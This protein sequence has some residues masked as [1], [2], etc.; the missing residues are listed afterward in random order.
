VGSTHRDSPH[1][2]GVSYFS[3]KG[4][5]GDGRAKPDLVAPGEKIVS[6]ATSWSAASPPGQMAVLKQQ[7]AQWGTPA[8]PAA[9]A[10]AAPAAMPPRV[11]AQY[12]EDSGTSMAAPHVSGAIAAFL[13]VRREYIGEPEKVKEVFVSTATDLKRDRYFQGTGLVDLMRAIQSV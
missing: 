4:P 7:L 2:Y 3:S 13:S 9:P 12:K 5:T 8:T 1:V 6:C 11:T 10:G